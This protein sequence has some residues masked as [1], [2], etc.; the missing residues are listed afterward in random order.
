ME[1]THKY[2]HYDIAS[3]HL[4]ISCSELCPELMKDTNRYFIFLKISPLSSISV[5]K[6]YLGVEI[7]QHTCYNLLEKKTDMTGWINIA[8]TDLV[9]LL[10]HVVVHLLPSF[11]QKMGKKPG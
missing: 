11:N 6:I 10:I 9:S 3:Y 7:P 8:G 1:Q 4:V 2:L 5:P